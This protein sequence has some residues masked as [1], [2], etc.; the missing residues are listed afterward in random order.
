MHGKPLAKSPRDFM[1]VKNHGIR[2]SR[3]KISLNHEELS[4]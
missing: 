2:D 1:D 3:G 4:S